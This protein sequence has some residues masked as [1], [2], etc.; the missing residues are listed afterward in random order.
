M[1]STRL[2]DRSY[3]LLSIVSIRAGICPFGLDS[4]ARFVG[5]NQGGE[6]TDLPRRDG[7]GCD[8]IGVGNRMEH[9]QPDS[10]KLDRL[11]ILLTRPDADS[12]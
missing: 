11:I 2:S 5:G 8:V 9:R 1:R 10:K 4:I 3:R 7:E 12:K 6:R